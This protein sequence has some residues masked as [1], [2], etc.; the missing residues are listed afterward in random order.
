[1]AYK[2]FDID[3]GTV[4]RGNDKKRA[5]K[6]TRIDDV[7]T[8]GDSTGTADFEVPVPAKSRIDKPENGRSEEVG[9]AGTAKRSTSSGIKKKNRRRS[10]KRR[11]QSAVPAVPTP[12]KQGE[13]G[14]DKPN[15]A[16]TADPEVAVPMPSP[17]EGVLSPNGVIRT[18]EGVQEAIKK[19]KGD[20]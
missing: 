8:A 10:S 20:K 13:S 9:T 6:I 1:M 15:A 16:G 18:D 17:N 3:R 5:I 14:V 2:G 4:G 12:E 19:L 7:G 11:V